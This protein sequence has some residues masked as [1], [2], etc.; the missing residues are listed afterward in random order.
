MVA[1]GRVVLLLEVALVREVVEA[2]GRVLDRVRAEGGRGAA[3]LQGLGGGD[4][5]LRALGKKIVI[6]SNQDW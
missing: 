4:T 6:L 5:T 2:A 1:L 3:G